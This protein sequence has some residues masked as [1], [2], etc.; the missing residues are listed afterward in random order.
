MRQGHCPADTVQARPGPA[1]RSR[2]P[3]VASHQ[4]PHRSRDAGLLGHRGPKPPLSQG[5]WPAM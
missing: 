2:P 1:P 4:Q 5:F 3:P